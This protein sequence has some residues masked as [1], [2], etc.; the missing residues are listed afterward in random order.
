MIPVPWQY[1]SHTM[2]TLALLA[3]TRSTA[4]PPNTDIPWPAI[5]A[6]A[7]G[8]VAVRPV[9]HDREA[10]QALPEQP[11]AGDLRQDRR[12]QRRQVHPRRRRVRRARSSRTT[13]TSA[14][15]RSRSRSRS[16]APCRS[17]TSASTCPSVFTVAIGTDA[18]GDAER[19]HPPARPEHRRRSSSRPRTS[20][21]ASC[22]R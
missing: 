10:V 21:S 4:A 13:P 1:R 12:R 3:Q 11:R 18:G 19:G 17:R 7:A 20:S 14:S 8:L 2:F 22:G 6:V 15:S 5:T 16:R 9:A